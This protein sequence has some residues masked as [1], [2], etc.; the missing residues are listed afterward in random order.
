VTRTTRPIGLPVS[1]SLAETTTLDARLL[2]QLAVLLLGHALATLLD[3]GTHAGAFRDVVRREER[4]R[5]RQP[6]PH[7]SKTAA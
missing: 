3:D 1:G 2:E 5:R 4:A 6:R 7:Q